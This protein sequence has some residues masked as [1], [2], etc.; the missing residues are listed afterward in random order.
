MAEFSWVRRS[1]MIT[2]R[3]MLRYLKIEYILL[4]ITLTSFAVKLSVQ[5]LNA[6]ATMP[7]KIITSS[8]RLEVKSN[9]R[10]QDVNVEIITIFLFMARKILSAAANILT[11]SMM[12]PK[13]TVRVVPVKL[14]PLHG[15]VLADSSLEITRQC[16]KAKERRRREEMW[17]IIKQEESYR[18]AVC[19]TE[20]RGSSTV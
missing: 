7:I 19:L 12:L 1:F 15:H 14:S 4:G 18:I 11:S 5:A 20:L 3:I 6:F 8:K 17:L 16:M 9:A 2:R 13:K 10:T